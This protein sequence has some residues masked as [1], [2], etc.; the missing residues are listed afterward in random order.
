MEIVLIIV[1]LPTDYTDDYSKMM[2]ALACKEMGKCMNKISGSHLHCILLGDFNC[3][4]S[5]S[6]SS[7]LLLSL[8]P[9]ESAIVPTSGDF[10]YIQPTGLVSNFDHVLVSSRIFSSSLA[11]DVLR[12]FFVSDYLP[13][14]FRISEP[15]YRM[16]ANRPLKWRTIIE[17]SKADLAQ[18]QYCL[19]N[20]LSKIKIPFDLLQTSVPI[21]TP[22]IRLKLNMYSS[23]ISHA[24]LQAE[25]QFVPRFRVQSP[26]SRVESPRSRVTIKGWSGTPSLV[27]ACQKAKF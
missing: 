24:L 16:R 10:T 20:L 1:D 3:D 2:F 19:D 7:A 23:L 13:L 15:F 6:E 12:E 9:N 26:R 14:S 11:V 21:P 25:S 22:E 8:I 18:Y 17:W 5:K 27:E 4:V